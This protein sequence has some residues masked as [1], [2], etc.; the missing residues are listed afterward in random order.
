VRHLILIAAFLALSHQAHATV[1]LSGTYVPGPTPAI[2][3]DL[4]TDRPFQDVAVLDVLLQGFSGELALVGVTPFFVAD[5]S[6][7]S[8]EFPG[9]YFD[10]PGTTLD[11]LL[12][13]WAFSAPPSG[14]GSFSFA[15]ASAVTLWDDRETVVPFGPLSAT[16]PIPEP[17]TWTLL[18]AGL[19]AFGVLA[20]RRA[21]AR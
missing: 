20:R 7:G 8:A 14:A 18:A 9:Y 1:S 17:S 19:A 5:L 16:V 11:G 12:L 10:P 3:L 4:H 2:W 21:V 13:R 15:A 6:L